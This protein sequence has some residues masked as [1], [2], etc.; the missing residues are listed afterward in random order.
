[1]RKTLYWDIGTEVKVQKVKHKMRKHKIT[2]S[3]IVRTAIRMTPFDKMVE[4]L[5]K[6]LGA[7]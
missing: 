6:E 4:E 2:E 3:H 1:M 5:N 7:T